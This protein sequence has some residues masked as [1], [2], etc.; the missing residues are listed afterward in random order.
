MEAILSQHTVQRLLVICSATLAA[1]LSATPVSGDDRQILDE[2]Y[3]EIICAPGREP[4]GRDSGMSE[5]ATPATLQA[6]PPVDPGSEKLRQEIEKLTE[7][8]KMRHL[9]A[10]KFMQEGR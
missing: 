9:D 3:N 10:I 8:A 6:A 1:F 2:L 4:G 5:P 7:E